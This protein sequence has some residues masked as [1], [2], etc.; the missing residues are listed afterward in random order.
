MKRLSVLSIGM[1]VLLAVTLPAAAQLAASS[2]IMRPP[3][4]VAPGPQNPSSPTGII[5]REF[6]AAYG[7]N[8][9]N[10]VGA[11]QTIAL[12]DAYDDPNIVSDVAFYAN[13]FHISPCNFTKVKLGTVTGQ[14]WDL[15]ESLDVQQACALAPQA[16]IVLVEAVSANDTDLYAAIQ[17]AVQAPYNATVVSMSW[18]EGEF[19]GELADD[20]NFRNILNGNGQPVTF[21]AATG[22][23]GHGTI[24]PSTSPY[25]VAAGG[26]SLFVATAAPPANPLVLDYGSESAWNGSGGGVSN[27][28]GGVGEPQPTF[29]NPACATWSTT[30]RCVPDIASDANPATGVP[31][32]DTFSYGGWVQVGGTSVATPDWASFFTLVN[33]GRAAL[34]KPALSQADADLYQ[35]YYSSNYSADF[36]DITTGTNGSCGS[37]C[38]AGIGYDL[39]TGIGSYQANVLYLAMVAATN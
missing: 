35:F 21:V 29:Q 30:Y 13:Y 22:D 33:S 28:G 26:T 9:I 7:F 17:V 32:Y 2:H 6:K 12:I 23:S 5:P 11:G 4:Q 20:S 36:H 1:M 24:Y 25:V 10:N 27:Y 15:E 39:V 34:G 19:S 8:A 38:D 16:N 14:G 18:G 3:I 37:E 31:V